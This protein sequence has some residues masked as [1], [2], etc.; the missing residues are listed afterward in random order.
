[1]VVGVNKYGESQS[2]RMEIHRIDPEVVAN[3]VERV[4]AYKAAQ[5][6]AVIE[7][8]LASVRDAAESGANLLPVMKHALLAGATLGQVAG[9]LRETF[10]EHRAR[11]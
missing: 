1:V 11:V 5:S 8:A 3:Q 6:V 7:P 10:G 4:K 9:A 2:T